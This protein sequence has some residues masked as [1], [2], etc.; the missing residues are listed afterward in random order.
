MACKHCPFPLCGIARSPR[1]ASWIKL[2]ASCSFI[3][4]ATS[5]AP[6]RRAPP[7]NNNHLPFHSALI[8]SNSPWQIVADKPPAPPS[9]RDPSSLSTLI[10]PVIFNIWFSLRKKLC[11]LEL[12]QPQPPSPPSTATP[13]PIAWWNQYLTETTSNGHR[14]LPSPFLVLSRFSNLQPSISSFS[15]FINCLSLFLPSSFPP[16]PFF[17]SLSLRLSL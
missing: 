8:V 6:A 10:R 12:P 4:T 9:L 14:S 16:S 5:G 1:Q 17:L 7:L 15:S 3:C 2:P 13:I 11:V